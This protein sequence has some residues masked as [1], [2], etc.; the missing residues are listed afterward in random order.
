MRVSLSACLSVH[1]SVCLWLILYLQF[2]EYLP[3]TIAGH[4]GDKGGCQWESIFLYHFCQN[5]NNG[6]Y[7]GFV[8]GDIHFFVK[9]FFLAM[10]GKN[11][12][13]RIQYEKEFEEQQI[14]CHKVYCKW[15]HTHIKFK[16]YASVRH[17]I[18][19]D[20]YSRKTCPPERHVLP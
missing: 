14:A 6:Q 19:K 20:M 12:Y 3:Q 5:W 7:K 4:S 9:K 13:Q 10:L 18:L 11:T 2:W 15:N 17:V 16:T 1:L 8:N